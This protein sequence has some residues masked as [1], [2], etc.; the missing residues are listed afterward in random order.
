MAWSRSGGR[1]RCNQIPI[2]VA[3]WHAADH[4]RHQHNQRPSRA[5]SRASM[6]S[7]TRFLVNIALP[8][9]PTAAH[10]PLWPR[11]TSDQRRLHGDT[12]DVGMLSL[13][14]ALIDQNVIHEIDTDVPAAGRGA[15]QLPL[16]HPEV[17]TDPQRYQVESQI[18]DEGESSR[19]GLMNRIPA[20]SRCLA[21]MQVEYGI[22]GVEFDDPVGIWDWC[23]G[24][25]SSIPRRTAIARHFPGWPRWYGPRS[26]PTRSRPP[27]SIGE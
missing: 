11:T 18:R 20:A 10:R 2:R 12:V 7:S 17:R 1:A 13:D 9:V 4:I 24:R 5:T 8:L 19:R 22:G 16:H 6:S 27:K 15:G 25:S 3:T 23:S 26:T 14:R 21:R